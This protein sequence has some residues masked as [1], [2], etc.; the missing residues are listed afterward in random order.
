MHTLLSLNGNQ[1]LS[2]PKLGAS[3]EGFIIEQILDLTKTRG[4]YFWATHSGAELDL[5]II[6]SGKR[7]GFEIKYT[8][9]PSRSRSI[10]IAQNDLKLDRLY[11]IYPGTQSF[12]IDKK[13]QAVGIGDLLSIKDL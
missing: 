13:I 9:A 8:D 6:K 5:L 3:W 7:I 2:H 10:T 12:Q 4:G 11:V 1:I